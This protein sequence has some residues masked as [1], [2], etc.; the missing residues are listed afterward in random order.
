LAVVC[1][2]ALGLGVAALVRAVEGLD[3][4]LPR[5]TLGSPAFADCWAG[6]GSTGN[7]GKT[8]LSQPVSDKSTRPWPISRQRR[9]QADRTV[10]RV[11]GR[12][13][14]GGVGSCMSAFLLN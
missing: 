9:S 4:G 1:F 8:E 6:I 5:V 13:V 11:E 12:V 3:A 7:H 10:D 2:L 14:E